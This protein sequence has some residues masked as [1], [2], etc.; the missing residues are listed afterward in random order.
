MHLSVLRELADVIAR[1]FS[2]RFAKLWILGRLEI[3]RGGNTSQRGCGISIL[4]ISLTQLHMDLSNLVGIQCLSCLKED[5]WLGSH[6]KAVQIWNVYGKMLDF[7]PHSWGNCVLFCNLSLPIM[8][9]M[10]QNT[11]R[12]IKTYYLKILVYLSFGESFG[13]GFFCV[14]PPATHAHLLWQR[15]TLV[16]SQISVIYKSHV[17]T[18][19]SKCRLGTRHALEE[20]EKRMYT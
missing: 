2:V 8:K 18:G 10:K 15:K 17:Y 16:L 20:Q 5:V 1:L 13:C 9:K 7:F 14:V 11:C 19:I 12:I 6:T 3:G 4:G